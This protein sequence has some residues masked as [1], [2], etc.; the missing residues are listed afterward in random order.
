LE[1]SASDLERFPVLKSANGVCNCGI[2]YALFKM[3]INTL[4]TGAP[5]Y[6]NNGET[7]LKFEHVI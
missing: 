7:N 3:K 4:K 5:L 2:G 6:L 1:K